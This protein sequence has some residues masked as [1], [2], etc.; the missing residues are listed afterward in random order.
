LYILQYNSKYLY[1]QAGLDPKWARFS[2]GTVLFS[3]CIRRAIEEGMEEF[4]FLQGDESYKYSWTK[5][6]R[7]NLEIRIFNKSIKARIVHFMENQ[8]P[9]IGKILRWLIHDRGNR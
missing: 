9:K 1:Y 6:A 8:R 5:T 4:D 2:P 3:Y 7:T